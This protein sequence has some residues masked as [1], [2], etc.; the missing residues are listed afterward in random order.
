MSGTY[1]KPCID[2]SKF[3]KKFDLPSS[4]FDVDKLDNDKLETTPVDLSKLILMLLKKLYLMNWLK[5]IMLLRL[6]ILVI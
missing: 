2:T 5:K 4:K 3:V 1:F 6:L